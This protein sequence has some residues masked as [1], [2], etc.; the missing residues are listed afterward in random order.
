MSIQGYL[1][2]KNIKYN[3][4]GSELY[5]TCP[6]CNK[7][8]LC[9]NV[10]TGLFQCWVCKAENPNS[11][12]VAGHIS[13][14]KE[15]WDD[16]I[17]LTKLSQE[18]SPDIDF[19][20]MAL[21]L[22]KNLINTETG[23][24]GLR[25]LAKREI[26]EESIYRFKL[27]LAEK[28][29]DLFISIPCFEDEIVKLIKYRRLSDEKPKYLREDKGKSVLFNKDNVKDSSEVFV[30]EGEIDA[31]TLIQ[32]G[33]EN[34]VS[35]TAGVGTLLSE[36]YDFLIMKEKL[37]LVFDPDKAGQN[38]AEN[39]W[40]TRLGINKC[41]NILLPESYDVNR[42][43]R[44]Y[45][46]EDF[47]KLS[48]ESKRFKVEGLVSLKEAII[49]LST[50]EE[51]ENKFALPWDS[52]NNLLG[53]GLVPKRLTI[54][55]GI[56]GVGKTSFGLQTIYYFTIKH[57]IPSLFFCL[58]M[59]EAMLATKIIQLKYDLTY[60]DALTEISLRSKRILGDIGDTPMY[61]GY[62]SKVTPDI[63]YNT[64]KAARDRYGV[65]IG[66][67]DNLQRMV[68][69]DKESDIGKASA[70]FK[71][72]VM[73]LNIMFILV[74]QPRKLNSEEIP[75]YDMLKGSSAI[76]AD[77]DEVI[78][79]HR[80]RKKGDDRSSSLSEET[81]IIVD[82]S[83]FSPGGSTKLTFIGNK[84]KFIDYIKVEDEEEDDD[85]HSL[86]Y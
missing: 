16:S 85:P 78:L 51:Q 34:V 65:R 6:Y 1:D 17:P 81:N 68:R 41:Y 14:L 86:I 62:S 28:N 12:Y 59:S 48:S 20:E 5:M 15:M 27:G 26:T 57:K 24:K 38:A 66:V 36:W 40:A 3:R 77:A 18:K 11:P 2:S 4:I 9:I 58:E 44:E 53:G 33:I 42:F 37:Y 47:N 21:R 35:S 46:I 74:S 7:E 43:F 39:E 69:S 30:T 50:L 76:P 56:P 49:E 52:V 29:S 45:N 19:T 70:I 55:G 80:E 79:V 13:Q 22:H 64:V 32:N 8:K 63:F 23:K 75:T 54:L 71:D 72:I 83:R 61:F 82:K 60:D 73:D 84:S 10:E 31:I 67:F 25:Y